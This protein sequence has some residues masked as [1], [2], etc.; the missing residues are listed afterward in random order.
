[1]AAV[2]VTESK[3]WNEKNPKFAGWSQEAKQENINLKI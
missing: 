2:M 3:Q 1:M